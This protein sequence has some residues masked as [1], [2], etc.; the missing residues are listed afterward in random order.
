MRIDEA[1][2]R[3]KLQ[4]EKAKTVA[5]RGST[6]EYVSSGGAKLLVTK[7]GAGVYDYQKI[8]GCGGCPAKH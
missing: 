6:T 1:T 5:Q 4:T 7:L 3:T 2:L 8:P